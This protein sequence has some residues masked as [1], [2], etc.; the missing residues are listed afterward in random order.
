MHLTSPSSQY[1]SAVEVAAD[2]L[3]HRIH[4]GQ[5]Q[6]GA[7]IRIKDLAADIGLSSTPVREALK[8]LEREGLVRIAPR[9]GV[10]VRSISV[11]EVLQVYAIK[12]A[13]EPLLVRWAMLR[14]TGDELATLVAMPDR[15]A[16]LAREQKLDEYV[17]LVEERLRFLIK[18]ARSDVLAT[19]YQTIDGRTRFMRYQNLAQTGRIRRSVLE[20]Q[21]MARAIERRDV[22]LACELT[23]QFVHSGTQSLLTL[24]AKT[25]AIT[26]AT[27]PLSWPPVDGARPSRAQHVSKEPARAVGMPS[28]ASVGQA[29][30]VTAPAFTSKA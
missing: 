2:V 6:E 7:T 16:E 11:D 12:Q 9:S 19:I 3:R 29:P 18:M 23:A 30:S 26:E 17:A 10:Y 14:G 8:L 15:L 28:E 21:Q 4:S 25:G 13:L 20:H 1:R 27:N 24:I 22:D 5:L